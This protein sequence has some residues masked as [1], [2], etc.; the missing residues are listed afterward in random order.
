MNWSLVECTA[1]AQTF[2]HAHGERIRPIQPSHKRVHGASDDRLNEAVNISPVLTPAAQCNAGCARS[3]SFAQTDHVKAVASRGEPHWR[4]EA[5]TQSNLHLSLDHVRI[6]RR[7]DNI[8]LN[9]CCLECVIDAWDD[10][11]ENY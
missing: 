9:V 1:R 7:H 8:R 11:R 10:R 5:D 2:L 3:N 6:E 4:Y